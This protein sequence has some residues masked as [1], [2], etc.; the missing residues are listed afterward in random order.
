MNRYVG[1]GVV[2]VALLVGTTRG[3]S[4]NWSVGG[5][6]GLSSL[7]GAAGFHLTPVADFH[8]NRTMGMGIEFSINTQYGAPLLLYPY[9][10]YHFDIR[11]SRLRP[12]AE[13]GPVMMLN[14]P[15]A[16]CLGV[17]FGGGVNITVAG[18]LYLTPDILLGPVFDVGGGTYNL[19]LY[20]NYYGIGV[21]SASS[22]ALPGQTVFV[23]CIRG[24][25]RYEL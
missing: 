25:I 10:K 3:T 17:L 4:Q 14:V 1:A 23:F 2:L 19:F 6:L 5:S 13:V 21:Y 20:G 7:G 15:D 18:N 8:F 9:F 22:Y 16:P 24:G 12:F 11:G